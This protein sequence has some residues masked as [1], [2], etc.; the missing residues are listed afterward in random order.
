ICMFSGSIINNAAVNIC[1]L[2]L[3][4]CFLVVFNLSYLV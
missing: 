2:N 1:D 3:V 4:G